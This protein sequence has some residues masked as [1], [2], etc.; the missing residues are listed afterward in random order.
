M[1]RVTTVADAAGVVTWPDTQR[2]THSRRWLCAEHG[3]AGSVASIVATPDDVAPRVLLPCVR[4]DPN[5]Q[6]ADYDPFAPRWD[7]PIATPSKLSRLSPS[8]GGVLAVAAVPHSNDGPVIASR[9]ASSEDVEWA[10]DGF[11]SWAQSA[12]CDGSAF[13]GLAED[14]PMVARLEARGYARVALDPWAVMERIPDTFDGWLATLSGKSRRAA[15]REIG[16]YAETMTF[17]VGSAK[18][19]DVHARDLL[20]D[21]FGK[22]GH[23]RDPS[24]VESLFER[25]QSCHEDGLRVLTAR[26]SGGRRA[27]FTVLVGDEKELHVRVSATIGLPGLHFVAVYYEVVRLATSLRVRTVHYGTGSYEG[28]MQRGCQLQRR[29]ALVRAL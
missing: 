1:H 4:L 6:H 23:P 21:K 13:L 2:L 3:R 29:I 26:D 14:S 24:R 17:H 28:K 8:L 5:H 20:V 27:A 12:D 9:E 7:D 16:R 10:V 15:L 25:L 11:E 18:E 22:Y 19:L